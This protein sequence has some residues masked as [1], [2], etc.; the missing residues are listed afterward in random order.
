MEL[1]EE[2]DALRKHIKTKEGKEL[3]KE[4]RKSLK[5]SERYAHKLDVYF[6]NTLDGVEPEDAKFDLGL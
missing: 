1:L 6:A 3:A 5:R 4:F 2:F